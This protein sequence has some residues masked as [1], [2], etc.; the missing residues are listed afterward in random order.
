MLEYEADTVDYVE[1]TSEL[2]L[3]G[4]VRVKESTWTIKGDELWLDTERRTGRSQGFL[5]VEDGVTALYGDSGEF[6]F[7]KQT[8]TLRGAHAGH[9]DWRVHSRSVTMSP[10]KKVDYHWTR[11]TSCSFDPKPHYHF[12]ASRLTVKPK[13]YMLARNA[14]FYLGKI[15][16]FYTPIL[17]K[18]LKSRHTLRWRIQPGYDRR[19][20]VFGRGTLITDHGPHVYSKL[21]AD[22][23]WSQGFGAG[24]ELHRRK[25]EDSRA[26]LFGYRIREKHNGQE[27]WALLGDAYQALPSSFSLQGRLQTQSDADFN[28]HY[29]RSSAF[30]VTQELINGGALTHQTRMTTTRLSYSRRDLAL[31]SKTDFIKQSESYPRLDF[32]TNSFKLGRL[33]WLNTVT[34]VADNT[35]QIGRPYLERKAAAEWE[36]TRTFPLMRGVSF[37]P[38][39]A[40][41]QTYLNRFDRPVRS[42][43]THIDAFVGRWRTEGVLRVATLDF[44]HQFRMRQIAD[45]LAED[46]AAV[47][48]GVEQ[49]R[50]GVQHTFRPR[51]DTLLRLQGG[52]DF[53]VFRDAEWG[54]RRRVEPFVADIAWTPKP[55]MSV[56]L[57]DEYSLDEGNR[58]FIG[59]ARWDNGLGRLLAFGGAYNS[60]SPD[61][62][63]AS[64]EFGLANASGTWRV[65]GALRAVM[66][67]SGGAGNL[68]GFR[69]FEKELSI[70]RHFHDFQGRVLGRL[71][72]GGVKEIQLRLD[73]KLPSFNKEEANRERQRRDWEAEWFPERKSRDED[74]F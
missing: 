18:S 24:A 64:T 68:H 9:T 41:G 57:R 3:R 38:K 74:R 29:A 40:Y 52:Y 28:N 56:T 34:A 45:K 46:A 54:F 42:T 22:Y 8:G 2:H 39:A 31:A 32:Q 35:Y 16:L 60:F 51:R 21:F 6:D 12:R 53:R 70:G 73:I 26:A 7:G 17:Y 1:A 65:G 62:Y 49:N 63:V 61:Q 14:V 15:P 11:F 47:D 23:Y 69:L 19:N 59:D 71:R 43:E 25:G 48:H 4:H 10:G 66:S 67:S 55:D 27:R 33:P 20:G 30:R 44:T 5:L 72:P 13:E 58:S 50:A 36:V 37:Q